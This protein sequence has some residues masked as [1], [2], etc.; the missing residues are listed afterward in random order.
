MN[1]Q[2]IS[3]KVKKKLGNKFLYQ[4]PFS[5]QHMGESI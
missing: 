4:S 5:Q 3:M 2:L 1:L